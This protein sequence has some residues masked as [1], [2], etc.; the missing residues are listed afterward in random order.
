MEKEKVQEGGVAPEPVDEKVEEQKEVEPEVEKVI[1]PVRS[2]EEGETQVGE[3]E[4]EVEK[5]QQEQGEEE[6]PENIN[7]N[8]EEVE[9]EQYWEEAPRTFPIAIRSRCKR[10]RTNT[11]VDLLINSTPSNLLRRTKLLNTAQ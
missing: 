3:S 10:F 11:A 1:E 4:P 2:K 9:A 8:E 5:V 6:E 7:G